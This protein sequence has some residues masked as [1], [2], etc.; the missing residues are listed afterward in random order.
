MHEH[1]PVPMVIDMR[2]SQAQL[3]PADAEEAIL[4]EV[5][6]QCGPGNTQ[7]PHSVVTK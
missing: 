3:L 7:E 6:G 5:Y 2:M 1:S 4:P